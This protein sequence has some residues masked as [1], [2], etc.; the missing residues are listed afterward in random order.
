LIVTEDLPTP[1]LPEE[2]PS[3]RVLESLSRNLGGASA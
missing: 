3:T 2:M 1:P